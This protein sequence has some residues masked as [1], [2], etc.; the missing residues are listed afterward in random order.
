MVLRLAA[1]RAKAGEILRQV[2]ALAA[3][4]INLTFRLDG[5][6]LRV[7][8]DPADLPAHPQQDR[9]EAGRHLMI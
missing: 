5:V 3:E 8:L 4:A 7:T 6:R 9:C 2:A 1:M